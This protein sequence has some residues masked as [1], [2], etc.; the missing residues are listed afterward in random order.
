MKDLGL[1][2]ADAQIQ[3][4]GNFFLLYLF[5]RKEHEAR[6]HPFGQR[7]NGLFKLQAEIDGRSVR[8][9][10]LA[11]RLI[12]AAAPFLNHVEANVHHDPKQISAEFC[13]KVKLAEAAAQLEKSGLHR[14][15]G[16]F[17]AAEHAQSQTKQRRLKMPVDDFVSAQIALLTAADDLVLVFKLA[18]QKRFRW[19][20]QLNDW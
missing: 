2:R 14:I 13:A 12:L 8:N 17:L 5:H 9:F 6:A 1:Y 18:N 3:K 20:I 15:F 19:L 11:E 7:R 4:L 16:V 10:Q